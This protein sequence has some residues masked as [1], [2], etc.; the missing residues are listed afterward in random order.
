MQATGI[1][2]VVPNDVAAK[3]KVTVTV[4]NQGVQA[5][6]ALAVTAA[7]PGIFVSSGTQ[8]AAINLRDD[9]LR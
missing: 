3:S 4:E 7:A 8:A 2:A 5:S 6:T 9:R 1:L